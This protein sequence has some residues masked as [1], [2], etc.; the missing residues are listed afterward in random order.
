M[1]RPDDDVKPARQTVADH[2]ARLQVGLGIHAI[3]Q[4]AFANLGN[5]ILHR[6]VVQA[7]HGQAV[8]RHAVD[9]LQEHPLDRSR[10]G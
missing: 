7:Q 5:Q 9:E 8:K 2:I 3:S 1:S 4:K 6:F 10:S